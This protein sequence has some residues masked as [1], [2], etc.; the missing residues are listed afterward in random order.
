M[1]LNFNIGFL[2]YRLSEIQNVLYLYAQETSLLAGAISPL[3]EGLIT[4]T[5]IDLMVM[6]ALK[7]SEIEGEML[8]EEDI[9]SSIR[10]N[11][12]LPYSHSQVT[13]L[14]VLGIVELM[15]DVHNMFSQPLS[16]EKLFI[17]HKMLMKDSSHTKEEL[18]CWRKNT[19]PMQI[20]S[21]P[22][23]RERGYYEAPLAAKLEEEMFA[24]IEWFNETQPKENTKPLSGPLR[25]AIAHLYFES[26]HT[27]L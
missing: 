27:P 25:A 1:G 8:I 14:R 5:L 18:G 12:G 21:G 4:D 16:A 6:G 23:G 19:K 26:I 2:Q 15:L 17:W 24:F 3:P 10:I 7:T 9:R 20:I 13:D 22:I 11:L